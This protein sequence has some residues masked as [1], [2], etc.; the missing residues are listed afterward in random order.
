MN[1]EGEGE[2]AREDR[3]PPMRRHCVSFQLDLDDNNRVDKTIDKKSKI[4]PSSSTEMGK[5]PI[6][7]D[8][9]CISSS[10]LNVGCDLESSEA[11]GESPKVPCTCSAGPSSSNATHSQSTTPRFR[12]SFL[13]KAIER[14]NKTRG[15]VEKT[16][17]R[18]L[19]HL[20]E[21]K[22]KSLGTTTRSLSPSSSTSSSSQSRDGIEKKREDSR[23]VLDRRRRLVCAKNARAM[24][25]QKLPMIM[26]PFVEQRLKSFHFIRRRRKETGQ[27]RVVHQ[28][29][30]D[31]HKR[32]LE[33]QEESEKING[34]DPDFTGK[35]GT[36][37][38]T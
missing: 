35:S 38:K 23:S 28:I 25:N 18:I 29:L 8:L 16:K 6:T 2:V 14:S 12:R 4:C 37:S 17:K 21:E 13:L 36:E 33:E 34:G 5:G 22:Q 20:E 3:E 26:M 10:L 32:I 15:W 9:S 30:V 7:Q 31:Q 27:G 1:D 19:S 24:M 11:T